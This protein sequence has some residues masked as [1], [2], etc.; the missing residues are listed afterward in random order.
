[1]KT[2][3]MMIIVIGLIIHLASYVNIVSAAPVY[4]SETG[5]YYDVVRGSI[6][7][8]TAKIQAESLS[9]LG[10]A[11]HLATITSQAENNFI[12]NNIGGGVNI[13]AAWLG[14]TDK[15]EEGVWEW[16]TG[17]SWEYENWAVT[18]PNNGPGGS[19]MYL[20]FSAHMPEIGYWNDENA[21]YDDAG[22][23]IEYEGIVP[24]PV[25]SILF[26]TGG[27]LLVGRRY[28]K[29]KKKA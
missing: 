11:G 24:E 12:L 25:S 16:V 2:K 27:T 13:I 4:Y 8:E 3:I 18:E 28:I 29:R 20:M 19:E 5:N 15:I 10:F 26:V 17:E 21:P 6:S 22:Y 1:M 7:W 14:G 23:V 9:Y